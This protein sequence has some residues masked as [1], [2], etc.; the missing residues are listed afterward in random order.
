MV[1]T[2][3]IADAG[4]VLI[5]AQAASLL[6]MLGAPAFS[7]LMKYVPESKTGGADWMSSTKK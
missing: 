1:L 6:A 2:D 5:F 7:M 3:A 4:G